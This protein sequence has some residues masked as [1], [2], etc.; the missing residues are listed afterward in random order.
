MVHCLG[1]SKS[2]SVEGIMQIPYEILAGSSSVIRHVVA[3]LSL[4]AELC[5]LLLLLYDSS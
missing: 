4:L 5:C 1:M 2:L 3:S